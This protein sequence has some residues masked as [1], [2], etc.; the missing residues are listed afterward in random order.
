MRK[1]EVTK[2]MRE[3][4]GITKKQAED[5]FDF[6]IQKMSVRL[7]DNGKLF[8]NGLGTFKVVE[9]AER[10]GRNPQTGEEMIIPARKV[11]K[12]SISSVLKEAIN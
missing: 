10:K 2:E 4:F 7:C 8:L 1:K 11:V 9:R 5:I 12:F 3:K 6:F